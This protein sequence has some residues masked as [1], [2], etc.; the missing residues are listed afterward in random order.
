[1]GVKEYSCVIL[2]GQVSRK[3]FHRLPCDLS[4]DLIYSYSYFR[5]YGIGT[6]RFGDIAFDMH[7]A[8]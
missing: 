1:M 8:T 4:H 3:K 2:V 6:F 7:S 5:L